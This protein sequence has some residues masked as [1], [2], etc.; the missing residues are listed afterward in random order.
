[1]PSKTITIGE[2]VEKAWGRARWLLIDADTEI[3][4]I[5]AEKGG[6][7]SLHKHEGK[8]N[9][10]FVLSGRLDVM[11]HAQS[12]ARATAQLDVRTGPL[13]VKAGDWHQF[14]AVTKCRAIEVYRKVEGA[15]R[16]WAGELDIVRK[17]GRGGSK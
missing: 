4:E 3:M 17:V 14:H 16:L 8:D 9:L 15:E 13:L 7:S 12:L 2:W 6:F 10:F 1:M 11:I 5:E